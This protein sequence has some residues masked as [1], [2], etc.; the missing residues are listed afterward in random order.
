[1]LD[2]P[3]WSICDSL[4]SIWGRIETTY[5]CEKWYTFLD[6]GWEMEHASLITCPKLWTDYLSLRVFSC[7]FQ[8]DFHV[9]D[10]DL[11]GGAHSCQF[12]A[13]YTGEKSSIY[14]HDFNKS[15]NGMRAKSGNTQLAVYPVTFCLFSTPSVPRKMTFLICGLRPS[16]RSVNSS[17][18]VS[19]SPVAICRFAN[20]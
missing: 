9:F 5:L 3:Y 15:S 7:P 13:S 8:I 1:M 14:H 10:P 11:T 17:M 6:I 18:Y 16:L 20:R 19:H 12:R 2:E 4:Q